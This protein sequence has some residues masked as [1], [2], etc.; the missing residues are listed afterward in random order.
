MAEGEIETD[1]GG[2]LL[3]RKGLRRAGVRLLPDGG[4]AGLREGDNI[5]RAGGLAGRRGGE[6]GSERAAS[7]RVDGRDGDVGTVM[8]PK[9][10][11][12]SAVIRRSVIS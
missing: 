1:F 12:R 7:A 6:V 2:L 8:G 9:S 11:P 4:L 10:R 3:A 5:G